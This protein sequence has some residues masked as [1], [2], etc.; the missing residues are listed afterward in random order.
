QRQAHEQAI[1]WFERAIELAPH[2][3][4]LHDQMGRS[5][6]LIGRLDV[7]ERA[8]AR[9]VELAPNE[10]TPR[11]DLALARQM[12]NRLD[13][14]IASFRAAVRIAPNHAAA[15]NALGVALA[16]QRR[17]EA[18]DEFRRAIELDPNLADAHFN[19]GLAYHRT[20]RH[21]HALL[22]LT[23]AAELSPDN[24]GL[25]N[26]LGITQLAMGRAALAIEAFRSALHVHP[27][28]PLAADNLLFAL[29]YDPA[30][31]AETLIREHERWADHFAAPLLREQ[32]PHEK[33]RDPRRRLR[34]G[35]VSPDLRGH[36]V[37]FFLEPILRHHDHEHFEIVCYSDTEKL[38]DVTDRLRAAADAW[39]D[40]TAL[41][42]AQFAE[43]VRQ[44]GID[45]LVDL[46]VHTEHNRLLAMARKP[47]PLQ[48][49]YLG[50]CG[51]TGLPAPAIDG[52]LT[53]AVVDPPDHAERWN[54]EPLVRLP[55]VFCCYQP[56]AD[57]PD[58]TPLPA[59]RD[60]FITFGSFNVLAKVTEETIA[61]W[62][63]ILHATPRSRL[64]MMSFALKDGGVVTD[65]AKRFA[66]YG[67]E[68]GRLELPGGKPLG[69]YLRTI[70]RADIALDTFPFNGHTTTCH[71]LWMG[72]PVISRSGSRPVSRVGRSL[73]RAIGLEDLCVDSAGAYVETAV[74][75]AAD[76]QRLT[77]LRSE[78]RPRLA[79][80]PLCDAAGFTRE[81]ESAYRA[82][83][84]AAQ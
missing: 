29:H 81:L 50:Y 12:Q 25:L 48:L 76:P 31:T 43:R 65:V 75:L 68:R 70:A 24:P 55:R 54:T 8:F 20:E 69:D 53:D 51:T 38:D 84:Q 18:I 26:L 46:A 40:A 2:D 16:M 72:V 7:A 80:S 79:A 34:I 74:R 9:A 10:L 41:T 23:R 28:F 14:A 64:L 13:D 44:D 47:A 82:M 49:S 59:E 52:R 67:I 35:Y 57:A 3:A 60:G 32:Q 19:L 71:A 45:I 33:D 36:A 15:H 73:L 11:L 17:V 62:S 42:D 77:C 30:T 21:A 37:S 78:L 58:I 6:G 22:T 63:K 61:L 66:A 56:P 4:Q 83:W 5:L 1:R 27:D 39:H